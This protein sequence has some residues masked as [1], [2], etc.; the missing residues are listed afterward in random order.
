MSITKNHRLGT[1]AEL[2]TFAKGLAAK[3]RGDETL[4]LSGDLGAGKT[5]FAKALAWH[6]GIE[7][8]VL[9]PTFVIERQYR[10]GAGR[11]MHHIDAYRI[12]SEDLLMIGAGDWLGTDLGVI[13]W[14]ER[15]ADVLP[16][17]TVWIKITVDPKTEARNLTL[18][19][20]PSREYLCQL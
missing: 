16:P 14:A 3:I 11:E 2:D 17:D 6:L 19:C 1:L 5:H 7:K 8:T 4:G 18:T 15:V 13:E 12:G 10:Y 9:S 20:P